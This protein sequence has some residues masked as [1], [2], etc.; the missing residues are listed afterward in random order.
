MHRVPLRLAPEYSASPNRLLA[1][2]LWSKCV[3]GVTAVLVFAMG[4][5]MPIHNWDMVAYTAAAYRLD[6]LRATELQSATFA[7]V[8][9]EVTPAEVHDATT[10]AYKAAVF[11]DPNSLEQN[12]PFYTIK[13]VYV[14]LMRLLKRAG[15]P[16]P[17]ASYAISAFFASL[18]ILSIAV[19][20]AHFGV[21]LFWTPLFAV[22]AGFHNLP[23]YSTPDAIACFVALIS[24]YLFIKNRRSIY[25]LAVLMPLIRT[26]LLLLSI[27]LMVLIYYVRKDRR[28]VIFGFL[29]LLTYMGVNHFA[30]SYGYI[31][32]FNFTFIGIDPYPR[33]M[34]LSVQPWAY[35]TPYIDCARVLLFH[36]RHTI[37]YILTLY[38]FYIGRSY[39]VGDDLLFVTVIS[40]SYA[41]L[42]IALFPVYDE[43]FF[44]FPASLICISLL[45][46]LRKPYRNQVG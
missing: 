18:S 4:L 39:K 43:R 44:A 12:L 24:V 10:S 29:A 41:L 13:I 16:Y 40:L 23:R 27:I 34:R 15:V 3:V 35:V 19:L 42:H 33:D 21:P 38:L 45:A 30:G 6:G 8:A 28:S 5:G 2:G 32:L 46:A 37:A 9:S 11:N 22:F 26:D 25:F 7:D 31:T 36:E 1:I 20:S 17:E 14:E